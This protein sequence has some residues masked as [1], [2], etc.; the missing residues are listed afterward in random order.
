MSLTDAVGDDLLAQLSNHLLVDGYDFI[1]DLDRSRG[2]PWSTCGPGR[3]T[4]ICSPSSPRT[5]SG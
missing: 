1:L 5:P 3:A 4:S 2:P